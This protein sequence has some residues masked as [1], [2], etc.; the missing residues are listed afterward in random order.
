MVVHSE[1]MIRNTAIG[2][3]NASAA[4]G[5]P[6]RSSVGFDKYGEVP[7]HIAGRHG[8]KFSNMGRERMG[9]WRSAGVE[10][11]GCGRIGGVDVASR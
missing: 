11:V 10:V 4:A 8:N 6:F 7:G 9:Q 1:V 2:K 5:F 3:M